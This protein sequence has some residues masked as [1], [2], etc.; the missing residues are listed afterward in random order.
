[1]KVF[2]VIIASVLFLNFSSADSIGDLNNAD[3]TEV[4]DCWGQVEITLL[5]AERGGWSTQELE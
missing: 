4:S 1:M 5:Q 3:S 2:I